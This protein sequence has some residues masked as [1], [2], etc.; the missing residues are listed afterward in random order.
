M[1]AGASA[2]LLY[3]SVARGT[4]SPSSDIDL[5]AVFDDLDYSARWSRKVELTRLARLAAGRPV[6]VRVTGTG[7]NWSHRSRAVAHPS[8]EPG[9]SPAT[10]WWCESPNGSVNWAK[11]I[12]M[13]T[14]DT[15]DA[16]LSLDHAN[17]ALRRIETALEPAPAERRALAAATPTTICHRWLSACGRYAPNRRLR[18]KPR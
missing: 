2:V 6:E 13:P 9:A 4:Q 17:D 11:E 5:V 8:F 14:S 15:G 18:W 10:L 7:P 3:G 12:G 1:A 16:A